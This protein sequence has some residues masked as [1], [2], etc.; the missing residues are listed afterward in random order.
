MP[1]TMHAFRNPGGLGWRLG[2]AYANSSNGTKPC[3]G[4]G[5][6]MM[7]H[8]LQADSVPVLKAWALQHYRNGIERAILF[9]APDHFTWDDCDGI[10][11]RLLNEFTVVVANLT[12]DLLQ[13]SRYRSEEHTSE[14]QS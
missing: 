12:P 11:E 10:E 5:H 7:P 9:H 1:L 2:N 13:S 8:A 4:R 6:A 14:L 3:C